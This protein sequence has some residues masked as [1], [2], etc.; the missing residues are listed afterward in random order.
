VSR[1]NSGKITLNREAVSLAAVVRSAR[2][3]TDAAFESSPRAISVKVAA[4]LPLVDGDPVRLVQMVSNLIGN[5][6]KFTG[7]D[8]RIRIT[9]NVEG[10]FVRVA[11]GDDGIGISAEKLPRVFDLFNQGDAVEGSGLGIGLTLV[12]DLAILHGG[13]VQA[14]SAGLGQG[15]EFQIYLPIARDQATSTNKGRSTQKQSELTGRRIAIV[16]DNKDAALALVALLR[17]HGAETSAFFDGESALDQ[18]DKLQP[19]TVL[20]DIGLPGKDGYEVAR[21]LRSRKGGDCPL[22]IAITGWSKSEQPGDEGIFDHHMVKPVQL[23]ALL[24]RLSGT[25][26]DASSAWSTR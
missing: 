19:D 13:R 22:L 5:S 2:E 7:P 11:I 10:D 3:A 23:Q 26:A 24:E 17:R 16:D 9:A 15:S 6:I 12:R 14:V 25:S 18:I 8:G 4:N 20:L 1:I 21:E